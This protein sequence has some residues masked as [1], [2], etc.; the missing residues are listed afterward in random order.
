MSTDASA[1][2]LIKKYRPALLELAYEA[3]KADELLQVER[4]DTIVVYGSAHFIADLE[5]Y[6][7]WVD[8]FDGGSE[9]ILTLRKYIPPNSE[10]EIEVDHPE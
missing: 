9:V 7:L 1:K 2:E 3:L 10:Q 4:G 6:R 5:G 8:V